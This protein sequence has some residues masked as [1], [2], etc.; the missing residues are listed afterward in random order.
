MK[1]SVQ[2]LR[3]DQYINILPLV[4][5]RFVVIPCCF[6]DLNGS[7]YQFAEGAPDGKYKAYQ[8]YISRVIETC[9]YE[10]QTEV[11]RIP[12]TKNIALVGMSRKRKRGCSN[13]AIALEKGS[14]EGGD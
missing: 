1:L 10:L 2:G 14:G 13:D 12:S 3:V 8:G 5:F 4:H 11:L 6:F 9:G 7:R